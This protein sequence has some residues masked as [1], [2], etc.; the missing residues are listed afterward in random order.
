MEEPDLESRRRIF[1]LVEAN[2]GIHF[3]EVLSRLDY[4]Q[5]TVQYHL[6][7]LQDEG[8]I[9]ASDDGKYTRYYPG[10]GFT[11]ADREV[12]NALR[13]TY[14]RRIVAYLL[15]DGPLTTSELADRVGKAPSTVSWH[16][17]KLHEAGLVAKE[18]E[19]AGVE[20]ALVD[21]DRARYLYTVYQGSFADRL[22]D[23]LLGLWNAY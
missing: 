16:L 12:M 20:Y 1:R 4:A 5:G 21:P 19:G 6:G 2:P 13:R 18:R 15:A 10:E 23:R 9:E 17:S 11:E 8:L 3:R 14:S 7:R 22:V